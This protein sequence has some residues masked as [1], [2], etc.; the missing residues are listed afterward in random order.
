MCNTKTTVAPPRFD[1]LHIKL[2]N[3]LTGGLVIASENTYWEK[4]ESLPEDFNDVFHT[5]NDEC[6][7]IVIRSYIEN[8]MYDSWVKAPGENFDVEKA[9]SKCHLMIVLADWGNPTRMIERNSGA[10]KEAVE[11]SINEMIVELGQLDG[12]EL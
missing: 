2:T 3:A 4:S 11:A 12:R 1:A 9:Y 6:Q 7:L 10:S 8:L 5:I